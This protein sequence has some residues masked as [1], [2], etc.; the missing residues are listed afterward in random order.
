MGMIKTKVKKETGVTL[1]EEKQ[2]SISVE[3]R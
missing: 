2:I 1:E 3:K